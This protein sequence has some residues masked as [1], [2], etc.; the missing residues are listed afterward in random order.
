MMSHRKKERENDMKK[1]L[2]IALARCIMIL[3]ACSAVQGTT[4]ATSNSVSLASANTQA[5][6]SALN[7]QQTKLQKA[8][9][10]AR[11]QLSS[12]HGDLHKAEQARNTLIRLH[13]PTLLLKAKLSACSTAG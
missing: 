12:A 8:I 1:R 3:S 13:E 5:N 2:I 4:P 7:E 10:A 11:V 9:D 6:C